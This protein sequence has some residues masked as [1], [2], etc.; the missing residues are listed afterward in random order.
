VL[1][2]ARDLVAGQLLSDSAANQDE[3]E[4]LETVLGYIRRIWTAIQ[5]EDISEAETLAC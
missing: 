1:D 4:A 2:R 3:E 5:N